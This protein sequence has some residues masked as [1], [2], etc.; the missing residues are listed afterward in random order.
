MSSRLAEREWAERG[1]DGG[2][3]TGGADPAQSVHDE[4]VEAMQEVSID[5]S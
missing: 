5:I 2:S 1:M 4:I 3:I